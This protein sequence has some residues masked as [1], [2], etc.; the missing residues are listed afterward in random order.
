MRVLPRILFLVLT[1]IGWLGATP[2]PAAIEVGRAGAPSVTIRDVYL[3]DGVAFVAI[4]EVLGALGL[5]G[6]W[7]NVA[8]VY[9][10]ATPRGEAVISPGS[11]YLRLGES[12]VAVAQRPRFI[13]GKLRVSEPFL[14]QQFAPFLDIPLQLRNLNPV[15]PPPPESPLDQLFSLLLLQ[16]PRAAADSQWVV[17]I[18]PGHGGQDSGAVGNDGVTEQAINLAVAQ[19]LQKLMKMRRDAPV[20]MTR[21]ADYAVS[22]A[23]RLEV[24]AGSRADMLLSL[25]A[26]AHFS[27][28]AAGVMLFIPP[29]TP[30]AAARDAAGP[31]PST[32]TPGVNAS[33]RLAESLRAA[34]VAAGLQVA[35]VQERAL[36]PLGQGNLPR[37]LVEMGYLSNEGDLFRL[38][39][40]AWQSSLARAL[41]DGVEAFLKNYQ[42]LQ[43]SSRESDQ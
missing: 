12:S 22:A 8:H 33:R 11:G 30:L 7:D 23:Q 35:P 41:F 39:D 40:P 4:D 25:H 26:Q 21:D 13:D 36:L 17:A 28:S 24:V 3:R 5:S 43:E 27:R 18:D 31:T 32:G 19:Q 37:V 10:I 42:Y 20:V 9:R 15:A 14:A 34:L 16:R 29:E 38:R 2:A 6:R 1:M